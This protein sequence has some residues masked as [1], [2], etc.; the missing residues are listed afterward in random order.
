MRRK[1]FLEDIFLPWSCSGLLEASRVLFTDPL[2]RPRPPLHLPPSILLCPLPFPLLPPLL[3]SPS[4]LG[5]GRG[6]GRRRPLPRPLR[7]PRGRPAAVKTELLQITPLRAPAA[8]GERSSRPGSGLG[9]DQR[10][11][12]PERG[13][14]PGT[15]CTSHRTSRRRKER[16]EERERERDWP[17]IDPS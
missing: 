6:S 15:V 1:V 11:G 17:R 14:H 3:L 13:G 12:S 5:D 8:A 10:R 16:R 2:P 4:L 9:C 7:S